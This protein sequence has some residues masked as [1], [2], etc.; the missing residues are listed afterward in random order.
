MRWFWHLQIIAVVVP[1][2][3]LAADGLGLHA[4]ARKERQQ[5]V[6]EEQ[7]SHKKKRNAGATKEKTAK[8]LAA[9]AFGGET[10]P[11]LESGD[12]LAKD[13][14]VKPHGC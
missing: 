1:F 12:S 8:T 9:P 5:E 11:K 2:R 4:V 13:F 10:T 3:E 14:R 7:S 6:G